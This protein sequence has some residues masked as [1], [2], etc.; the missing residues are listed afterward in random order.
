MGRWFW[1]RNQML[2]IKKSAIERVR[3]SKEC[4]TMQRRRTRRTNEEWWD[5]YMEINCYPLSQ[6]SGN[7]PFIFFGDNDPIFFLDN[8]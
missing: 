7:P 1:I 3:Q 5:A 4:S 2:C 6:N 8:I